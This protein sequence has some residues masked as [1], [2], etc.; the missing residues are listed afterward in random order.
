MEGQPCGP[1]PGDR[2]RITIPHELPLDE[3]SRVIARIRGLLLTEEKVDHAV[4][5]LALA[6]RDAIPGT[7][8][9]GVSLLDARG[10]RTSSGST[11][12]TVLR[13]DALQY[14]LGS[15]PCLTA[16]AAEETVLVE[17]IRKDPR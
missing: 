12:Q 7:V 8:G 5:H 13:A 17:D 6:I 14:D 4:E 16:W 11:D 15:G 9:A 1:E 2:W 3:L 10:N